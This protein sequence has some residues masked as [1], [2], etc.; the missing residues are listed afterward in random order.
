LGIT[1]QLWNALGYSQTF[2]L[3]TSDAAPLIQAARWGGVYAVSLLIVAVNASVALMVIEKKR[4]SN[5]LAVSVIVIVGLVLFRGATDL[6]P[7]PTNGNKQEAIAEVVAIQPNVPMTPA[8]S[9]AE[10]AALVQ[11]H[12]ELS[13]RGLSRLGV[14]PGNASAA[15]RVV[16]WPESPMNFTYSQDLEF[17]DLVGTFARTADAAV[18]FNSME[19]APANGAYNSAVMIDR[20]GHLVTRYDKI[21]LLPFGEYVPVPRWIPGANLIPTMV[22]DFTPGS[23]YPQMP[24]GKGHAGVFICFESAFPSIARNFTD[25]GADVLINISNDG[26]LGPTAV[27][28]QHLANAIFRAVENDRAIIRVTNTGITALITPRGAVQDATRGFEPAVRE[29]Q[30]TAAGGGKTFYT[31]YGDVV[32]ALCGV[33]TLFAGILTFRRPAVMHFSK[34]S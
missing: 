12:L 32:A 21:R 23:S 1:G 18:I 33:V 17:Q 27:M 9:L 3:T 13:H 22:G 26:Y 28:R 10:S 25:G 8:N 11:R 5:L 24:F 19:P 34:V 4:T 15:P 2:A 7:A 31:R 16:I 14:S 30:I 20:E 29:W 6:G